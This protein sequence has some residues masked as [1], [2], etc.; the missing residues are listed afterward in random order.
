[1]PA[2]MNTFYLV[3]D[4]YFNVSEPSDFIYERRKIPI[5]WDFYEDQMK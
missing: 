2:I 5:L 4:M 3:L 1:M